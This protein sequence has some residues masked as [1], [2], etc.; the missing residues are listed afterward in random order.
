MKD[1]TTREQKRS[2]WI[3]E[4][5]IIDN[6]FMHAFFDGNKEAA[7]LVLQIILNRKD[8]KVD[9]IQV[10]KHLK[11]LHGHDTKFD[12]HAQDGSGNRFDVEV[13]RDSSGANRRRARYHSAMLDSHMLKESQRYDEL[14]D[15]Y[16]IFITEQ[17]VLEQGDPLYK[18][19]RIIL[20]N[21]EHFGDGGHIIYVN[22]AFK[23]DS[24]ELGRLMHDLTCSNPDEMYYQ[25]L[26]KKVR[27][28]KQDN[29]GIKEM[30]EY[31][32]KWEREIAEEA[33]EEAITNKSLEIAMNL[34]TEGNIPLDVIARTTGLTI[35]KVTE[36]ARAKA[37]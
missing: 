12:V 26:A 6:A 37:V 17:D 30:T 9:D 34:I 4:A 10:E 8:F 13:Q 32:D 35:E 29:R 5:R 36:L 11:N 3:E 24:T 20:N 15:S 27:Y 19:E 22:G 7:E 23:D 25:E 2:Q 16:V 28:L 14:K 18:I 1:T 31:Y 21:D 33:A